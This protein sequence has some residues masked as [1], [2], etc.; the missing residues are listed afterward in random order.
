MKIERISEN[1]I[2]CTLTSFDLSVRDL[3]ISELAYGTEKAKKLF[4][5]MM[6]RASNEVGFDPEGGPIMIEAVPFK[7]S[8]E[9][10]IT[11]V[12]DP[13]ELDARFS[14]F[15]PGPGSKKQD[16]GMGW[17]HKLTNEILEGASGFLQQLSQDPNGNTP[18]NG[19][20]VSIGGPE[21]IKDILKA[22]TSDAQDD[23][24]EVPKETYR[25]VSFPDLDA[26][27]GGAK[28]AAFFEG[29][30]VLYKKSNTSKYVLLI[31][32]TEADYDTFAKACNVL[33]EYGATVATCEGTKAYYDEHYELMVQSPAIVKLSAIK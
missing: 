24:N 13:E 4:Q 9:L 25:A 12:D 17:L 7:D 26:C 29:E 20:K 21:L 10:V 22:K 1:S 16:N 11:R 5:E 6:H 14:K 28:A 32:G 23:K 27:V 2:K 3:N 8:V 31:K 18:G 19:V 33:A 15:S 30:S